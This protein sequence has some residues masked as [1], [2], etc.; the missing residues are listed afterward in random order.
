[1]IVYSTFI[2]KTGESLNCDGGSWQGQPVDE[3]GKVNAKGAE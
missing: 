1:M 2:L 3:E